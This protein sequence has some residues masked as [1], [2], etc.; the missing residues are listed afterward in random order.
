MAVPR[1][2]IAR[3]TMENWNDEREYHKS[4]CP[5]GGDSTGK[6]NSTHLE[7]IRTTPIFSADVLAKVLNHQAKPEIAGTL[8]PEYGFLARSLE[9][10]CN[11][12]D[13]D[14][15][16]TAPDSPI[17]ASREP[18]VG[19]NRAESVPDDDR[20]MVNMNAP[21][22]AFICG[23]QGSG[24]SYT[25]SCM[26]ENALVGSGMAKL[27]NKLAGMV[28][29]YDKFTAISSTQ[30]C[31]AAYLASKIP[32]KVLVSSSNY[33]HM[34]DVYENLPGFPKDAK[35]PKVMSLLLEEKHLNVERMLNLMAVDEKEGRMAL[36]MEVSSIL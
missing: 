23:S 34:K 21:W 32:V 33:K 17:T 24:K 18:T 29:H 12:S 10:Y 1:S 19:H 26:L 8:L 9:E 30:V 27:P 13:S 4:M 25:L 36:Y 7:E 35:K 20:L 5:T 2:Q 11:K 15:F 3:R 22:S 28:F 6:T 31:E 16:G 14:L